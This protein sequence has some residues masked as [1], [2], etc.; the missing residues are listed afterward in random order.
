MADQVEAAL[1]A[2]SHSG[3]AGLL[4]DQ[5]V[6]LDDFWSRADVEVDG[7]EEIQ[8][9]VRFA[10]FHVLQ[11]GARAEQRAIPAKGLTGSGYDGHAFWDTE[12]F[13]LPLL[14]YT[15]PDAVAEALRWR[16]STLDDARQ[17]AAQLGLRGAAFPWRTI[18]GSEGSAYWAGG[19]RGLPCERRYRRC[20]SALHGRD[21]ERAVRTRRRSRTARGDRPPVAFARPP[22][23]SRSLPH[24]R[25]HR[26]GRVQRDR[27][28]QHLHQPHGAGEPPCRLGRLRTPSR[29]GR[30]ARRRRRGERGLAG[31]RRGHVHPLRPRTRRARTA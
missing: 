27:R 11:A 25:R 6:Y 4:E 24:R 15:A 23:P 2:A 3:W 8:Q 17:R 26:P 14:T 10:L 18:D 12:A 13:V 19:H 20:R 16:H 22:R 5:R 31:R 9:A 28:R 30:A 21:R 1:A 29:A 7:D